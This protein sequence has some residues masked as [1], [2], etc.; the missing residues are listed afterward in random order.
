MPRFKY[1]HNGNK[2]DQQLRELRSAVERFHFDMRLV[3]RDGGGIPRVGLELGHL[4]STYV[5]RLYEHSN[6]LGFQ[7]RLL[8]VVDK[9]IVDLDA[10]ATRRASAMVESLTEFKDRLHLP[11]PMLLG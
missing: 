2:H 7:E 1:A 6:D 5:G 11:V 8:A 4:L 3:A 10:L 9:A